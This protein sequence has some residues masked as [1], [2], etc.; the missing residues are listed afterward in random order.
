MAEIKKWMP[1]AMAASIEALFGLL[2]RPKN[3]F[4]KAAL[5]LEK[6]VKATC[7]YKKKNSWGK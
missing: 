5:C 4:R 1:Q 6:F 7:L 2:G 3:K